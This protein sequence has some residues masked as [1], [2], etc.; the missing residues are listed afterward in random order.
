[1]VAV[2]SFI[3]QI[4]RVKNIGIK[5]LNHSSKTRRFR[6]V[7]HVFPWQ[8]FQ[9]I[10]VESHSAP[11]PA[12]LRSCLYSGIASVGTD[13]SSG[14]CNN[15][16][17]RIHTVCFF[18]HSN[19]QRNDNSYTSFYSPYQ[20]IPYIILPLPSLGIL[21]ILPKMGSVNPNWVVFC[22]I[23]VWTSR[24]HCGKSEYRT[25]WRRATSVFA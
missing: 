25:A 10:R 6:Q 21:I 20:Q 19:A 8:R 11:T 2:F 13:T 15:R 7:V 5:P 22:K 3:S 1:M 4:W 24:I 23:S 18:L 16:F 17:V 14:V 9:P 12:N